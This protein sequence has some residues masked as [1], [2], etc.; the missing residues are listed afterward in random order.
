MLQDQPHLAARDRPEI[1]MYDIAL[2]EVTP[3]DITIH[4][5]TI[6][7]IISHVI[8]PYDITTHDITT[9]DTPDITPHG[10][11]YAKRNAPR[12]RTPAPLRKRRSG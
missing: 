2:Y 4:D 8:I 9:H 12:T 11:T 6:H 7:D 10:M 1:T 3:Y 5:I